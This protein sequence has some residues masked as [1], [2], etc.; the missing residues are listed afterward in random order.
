MFDILIIMIPY[1][2]TYPISL[3]FITC[4]P[5]VFLTL[6]LSKAP[7]PGGGRGDLWSPV[8]SGVAGVRL[9]ALMSSRE[10]IARQPGFQTRLFY[11]LHICP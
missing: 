3:T 7:P 2:L 10:S 6:A 5:F 1:P 11:F 8:C 9:G 4:V